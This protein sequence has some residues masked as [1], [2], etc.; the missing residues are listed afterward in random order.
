MGE[1]TRSEERPLEAHPVHSRR[2]FLRSMGL[3][4]VAMAGASGC[5]VLNRIDS[6]T[7]DFNSDF[8]VLN[9]AYSLEVMESDFYTRV[10][11]SPPRD[12]RPGELEV[13]R[14]IWGHEV[15]H[16]K[17]FRRA[18]GPFKIDVPDRDFSSVNFSSRESVL[19]TAQM[20]ENNGTAA[21]NGAGKYLSLPEFLTIAGK[22]VSVEA[23]H[24]AV[25]RDLL[26]DSPRAFADDTLVD[27]RG[28]DRALEP[29]EMLDRV[30]PFFKQRLRVVGA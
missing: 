16:R 13:L 30:A 29:R 15:S 12:L 25:L 10:V 11:N 8:G 20:F 7:L 24:G 23:R 26:F 14:D 19:Q 5:S 17:F 18:I 6:R 21:Y 4:T 27:E 28:M 9:Y 22:I 2:G 3:G 1:N